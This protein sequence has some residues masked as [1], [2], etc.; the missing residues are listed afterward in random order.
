MYFRSG[1][2]M[3]RMGNVYLEELNFEQAFVLFMKFM[4]LFLE[5]IREHPDFKSVPSHIVA[6]NRK[7][8][9]EIFPVA[10][11]LK[12]R[13]LNIY[14]QQ[15]DKYLEEKKRYEEELSK[16]KNEMIQKEKKKPEERNSDDTKNRK[17]S[18]DENFDSVI[19]PVPH[20]PD[21]PYMYNVSNL[22]PAPETKLPTIS[23]KPGIDRS[24]KPISSNVTSTLRSVLV[25]TKMIQNFLVLSQKNTNNDV[26]TCGILAGKLH[27]D[28]L[29]ITHLLIPKQYGTANSCTTDNEE[30]IFEYQDKYSLITLGWIHTHPS[31]TAFLSSVDLHTHCSYQLMMPEAL[32]IVC[33][34]RYSQTGYYSLTAEY[35]LDFIANCRQSGFHPHPSDPPLYTE[36]KHCILDDS[37]QVEILDL[38][39]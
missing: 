32:A 10:E 29:T 2:E 26:E 5:K 19:K 22:Y 7:V 33:S 23:P 16:K 35:G 31:Q 20:L 9:C 18:S 37:G 1:N 34:P 4:T 38:R 30:E 25:P 14:Q 21:D 6:S 17:I 13:L 39:T 12:E 11:K 28:K 27:H 24:T 36:A 8:L 15:Y 3:I